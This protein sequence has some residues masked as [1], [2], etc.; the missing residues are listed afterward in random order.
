MKP[1]AKPSVIEYA[2]TVKINT[3][4]ADAAIAKSSQS[5]SFKFLTIK[6]PTA[7]KAGAVTALVTIDN[8][9]DKKIDKMNKIPVTTA[10]KPVRP[11]TAIPA[12]DS[13]NDVTVDVPNAAPATVPTA[14]TNNAFSAS[15]NSPFS[16][17]K[18]ASPP[19]EI[20]VPAVIPISGTSVKTI[21]NKAPIIAVIS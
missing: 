2:N 20:N 3:V 9:G 15:T 12:V 17:I 19:T 18:P 21:A 1:I 4:N 11:P 16:S 8:N 13:T 5:T 7:I 6:I 10:V 14:S